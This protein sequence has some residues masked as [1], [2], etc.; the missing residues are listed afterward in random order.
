MI[1]Q[2]T[3]AT[4]SEP[5]VSVDPTHG[6]LQSRGLVGVGVEL[7]GG[8]AHSP[9]VTRGLTVLAQTVTDEDRLVGILVHHVVQGL[10]HR[11]H[12]GDLHV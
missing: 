4:V 6:V 5:V 10:V 7:P 9:L 11:R 8:V 3:L 12:L 1:T 2:V